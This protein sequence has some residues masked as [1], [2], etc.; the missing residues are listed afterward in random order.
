MPPANVL[1]TSLMEKLLL[2]FIGISQMNPL[3]YLLP[4]MAM[5]IILVYCLIAQRRRLGWVLSL[6]GKVSPLSRLRERLAGIGPI[7]SAAVHGFLLACL[8]A[9]TLFA[10]GNYLDWGHF[11]NGGYLNAYE[12]YHYYLGTKYAREIGYT[13]LYAASLVADD[14]TGLKFSNDKKSI[15]NLATGGYIAVSEILNTREQYKARFSPERWNE[16]VKDVGWFKK[17]LSTGRWNGVLRDKGYNASPVWSTLVGGLLTNRI[18]TDSP[19]GMAFLSVI[20]LFLIGLAFGGVVWAFGPRAALLMLLLLGTHYMMHFSH[21]KGALMRTDF[22]VALILAV[23]LVKKEHYAMAGV[24]VAYSFLARVFPGVFLFGLGAKLF[25]ELTPVVGR[26]ARAFHARYGETKPFL[27]GLAVLLGVHAAAAGILA[28]VFV[29]LPAS[30]LMKF[31][32]GLPVPWTVRL[33]LLLPGAFAGLLLGTCALW[34]LWKGLVPTRYLR[35][36]CAFAAAVALLTGASLAYSGG[37]YLWQDFGSKIGR[38]NQDISGWRIGFKYIFMANSS[39]ASNGEKPPAPWCSDPAPEAKDGSDKAPAKKLTEAQQTKAVLKVFQPKLKSAL[40][41][42][43]QRL[44][45]LI[46]AAALGVCLLAAKGLK[47][48]QALTFSF[49]PMFFLVAPTYYYFIILLV[50]MLFFAADLERPTAPWA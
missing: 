18:S 27:K 40:Y 9:M 49:V 32:F 16:W 4:K 11:R 26:A 44:W 50:P 5:V 8:A 47:D 35:F 36:F 48:W 38:H 24:C 33:F 39:R 29:N 41:R 15:R 43:H 37:T 17:A 45:W 25:W 23:C 6:L 22:A 21:M 30:F 19:A 42:D 14:E 31:P 13:N 12:F 20:D 3:Y 7:F 34:G 2:P 10:A 46:L 1:P 28:T